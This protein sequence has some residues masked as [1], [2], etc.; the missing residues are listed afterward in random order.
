M[1][2]TRSIEASDFGAA[3][4]LN[5]ESTSTLNIRR[6]GLLWLATIHFQSG[7]FSGR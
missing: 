1:I 2:S 6:Y 7:M 5:I 3:K 4:G